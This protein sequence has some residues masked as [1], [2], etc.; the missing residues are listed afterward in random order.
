MQFSEYLKQCREK[1]HL[2]QEQLTH[3]LYSYDIDSFESLDTNT[4]SKW[5]RSITQPIAS[6]QVRLIKY[7]QQKTGTALPCLDNYTI[8][9]AEE[10]ICKVGM[11]NLLGKSK[12][13]IY[14]FPSEM[15]SVNDMKVYPLRN[16]ERMSAL[17]DSN[18]P[19]HQSITPKFAQVGRERFIE[20]AL[21]P[22]SLFLTC[23]YK[24]DFWGLFFSIKIKPDIF[25]KVMNFEMK[26]SDI[27]VN[28][29]AATNE[30]GSGLMLS[31][32]AMNKMTAT[33]L[34]IRYYAHLIAN[35]K[36]IDEIGGIT[37]Q[38]DAKKIIA[39]M[40]L[41]YYTSKVTDDNVE[42]QSF[43]QTLPNLLASEKVVKILLSKQECPEE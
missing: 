13:L 29:F 40:N 36:Y 18:M 28:D 26:K 20:W 16:S 4:I 9:E 25:N 31:F 17:I 14:D 15:M 8:E 24:D 42:I 37:I 41:H 10:L 19:L 3:E 12:K 32:F 43:R 6:K 21:H 38:D 34:F 33:L 23:E 7:F 5:E 11:H 2:T 27:T 1:N 22:N 39:N 30:M 35:Q